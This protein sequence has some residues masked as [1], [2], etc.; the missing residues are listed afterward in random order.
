MIVA[1]HV[2]RKRNSN[3]SFNVCASATVE[4]VTSGWL[5]SL[6]I[7]LLL[8][9]IVVLFVASL[10]KDNQLSP[11]DSNSQNFSCL[12]NLL[13]VRRSFH[14]WQ[15]RWWWIMLFQLIHYV[16]YKLQRLYYYYYNVDSQ[17][18]TIAVYEISKWSPIPIQNN[19]VLLKHKSEFLKAYLFSYL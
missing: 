5:K 11:I 12:D 14:F 17:N 2:E 4:L 18:M 10:Y 13:G 6:V 8:L 15:K 3:T 1:F 9:V 7:F 16:K 19:Q